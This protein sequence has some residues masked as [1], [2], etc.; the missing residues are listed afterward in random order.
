MIVL[1]LTSCGRRFFVGGAAWVGSRKLTGGGSDLWE[2]PEGRFVSGRSTLL[3]T[4][5]KT[6]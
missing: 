2:C 1:S 4:F 3:R 6:F 5:L